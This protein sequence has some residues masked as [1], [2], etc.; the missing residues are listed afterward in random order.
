MNVSISGRHMDVT[1]AIRGHVE[2]GLDKLHGHFDK[3]IDVDVVLSVEKHRRIAEFNVH[4]N[5][6][7]I[8]AK[9]ASEDL[10]A[11]IDAALAKA[12]KQVRKYKGR[13]M[14]HQPRSAREARSYSHHV[15]E[16]E[17]PPGDDGQEEFVTTPHRI[18]TR[19]SVP[20]KPMNVE[21][22]LLQLKLQ[23]DDW[24]AFTNADTDEL[25]VIYAHKDGT[26][27]LIESPS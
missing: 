25:N 21:E 16:W 6:L 5:G 1:D 13:I 24:L 17:E 7:R 26:Y 8:N 20:L 22:A 23:D 3:V 18:I 9:E 10:Y 15:I 14:R 4:A 2:N 27:G 19:E 11:A 12:E